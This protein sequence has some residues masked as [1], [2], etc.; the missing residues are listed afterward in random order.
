MIKNI[1]AKSSL[2]ESLLI[3][4]NSLDFANKISQND[5]FL[6]ILF[7]LEWTFFPRKWLICWVLFREGKESK[8]KREKDPNVKQILSGNSLYLVFTWIF[9]FIFEPRVHVQ[10]NQKLRLTWVVRGNSYCYNLMHLHVNL[11][12]GIISTFIKRFKM[13]NKIEWLDY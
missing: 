10:I 1:L 2:C 5:L 11:I 9:S 4:R 3:F 6:L 7:W 8:N 13:K 12:W